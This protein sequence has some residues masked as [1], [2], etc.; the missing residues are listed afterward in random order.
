[1]NADSARVVTVLTGSLSAACCSDCDRLRRLKSL[2]I[3]RMEH[4]LTC[5]DATVSVGDESWAVDRFFKAIQ[6]LVEW[7]DRQCDRMD[8]MGFLQSEGPTCSA[9]HGHFGDVYGC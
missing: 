6:D 4:V 2:A 1:M 7:C 8:P 9:D 3:Q 5:A